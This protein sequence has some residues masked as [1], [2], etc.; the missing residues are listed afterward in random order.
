MSG[1][2]SSGTFLGSLGPLRRSLQGRPRPE[3]DYAQPPSSS[4]S[5]LER[6]GSVFPDAHFERIP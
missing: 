3:L 1:D 6:R 4:L 5:P 2:V